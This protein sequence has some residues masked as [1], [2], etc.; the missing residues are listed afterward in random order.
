[1]A[2]VVF[3]VMAIGSSVLL[4]G[5][6][7]HAFVDTVTDMQVVPFNPVELACIMDMAA[8]NQQTAK[9]RFSSIHQAT[10]EKAT[11]LPYKTE[12][13]KQIIDVLLGCVDHRCSK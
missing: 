2:A 5:K 1:N 9:V 10:T 4:D 11:S 13:P 6:F 7:E 3:G 12:V 8:G